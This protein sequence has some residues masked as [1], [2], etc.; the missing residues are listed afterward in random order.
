MQGVDQIGGV[1]LD[2]TKK[3]LPRGY[4][5]D[6]MEAILLP[7]AGPGGPGRFEGGHVIPAA[8]CTLPDEPMQ[9][10]GAFSRFSYCLH[11]S[12]RIPEIHDEKPLLD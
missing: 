9:A 12:T 11:T 10:D 6:T 5:D 2:P 4:M 3:A 8:M 1:R 7:R